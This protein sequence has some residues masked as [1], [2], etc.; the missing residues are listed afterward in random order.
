[1]FV[2]SRTTFRRASVAAAIAIVGLLMT[3]PPA[4][5][6]GAGVTTNGASTIHGDAEP[7]A[8]LCL[9]FTDT[10]EINLWNT[11]TF[12]DDVALYDTVATFTSEQDFFFSPAGTFSNSLCTTPTA[13]MGTLTVSGDVT[14]GSVDA[15]Y[16]RRTSEYEIET[17]EP[18]SCDGHP[19]EHLKFIGTQ[20]ACSGEA[21]DPCDPNNTPNN[22]SDNVEFVGTYTQGV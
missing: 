8:P 11:G 3:M 21:P 4:W 6:H 13:V 19:A 20:T 1:M 2:I 18:T 12:N 14:C 5:A 17:E 9:P 16:T 10:L 7:T 15:S 22:D